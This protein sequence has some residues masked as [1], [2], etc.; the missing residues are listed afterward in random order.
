MSLD[1]EAEAE[2]AI[3]GSAE[4]AVQYPGLVTRI[5]DEVSVQPRAPTASEAIPTAAH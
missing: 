1:L 3:E 2:L 5:M 4:L